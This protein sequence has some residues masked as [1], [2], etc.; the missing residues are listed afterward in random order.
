MSM[1]RRERKKQET[2]SLLLT[3]GR[4]MFN[5]NGFEKVTVDDLAT[6][7]GVSRKT[8]FNYYQGKSHLLREVAASWMEKNNLWASELAIGEDIESVLVPPNI[9]QVISWVLDNRRL[10]K[11]VLQYTDFF[12]TRAGD[13]YKQLQGVTS[14]SY[15]PR[16]QRVVDAQ[17]VGIIRCDISAELVCHIYDA[18]RLDAVRIWLQKPDEEANPCDFHQYYDTA[19][20]VLFKGFAPD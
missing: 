17:A 7:A 15:R 14:Q 16:L 20:T 13:F 10:L 4:E 2:R 11:M 3:I 1:S 9:D 12:E 6:A 19:K 5:H 8:F 18:L